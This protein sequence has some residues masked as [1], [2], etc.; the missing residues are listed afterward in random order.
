MKIDFGRPLTAL[1]GEPLTDEKDGAVT[2]GSVAINALMAEFDE[3]RTKSGEVKLG[4]WLLA[5]RIH[6]A[7]GP[8]DLT[9]E[10]VADIKTRIGTGYGAAIVGPAYSIL[11]G[12]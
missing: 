1:D 2:L 7:D 6:N 5:Q 3:D 9:P 8:R 4:R 11:N 10:E 12:S